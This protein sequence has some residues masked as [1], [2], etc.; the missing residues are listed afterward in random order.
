MSVRHLESW[1]S[2]D[3]G[4]IWFPVHI[5]LHP[6]GR[7]RKWVRAQIAATALVTLFRILH[8]SVTANFG[9][10]A[11][12]ERI[13]SHDA[14][15]FILYYHFECDVIIVLQLARSESRSA[16]YGVFPNKSEVIG[17]ERGSE[18]S[19]LPA[20]EWRQELGGELYCLRA[21]RPDHT[22][23]PG[24]FQVPLLE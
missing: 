6:P 14:S 8:L 11:E 10:E 4:E 16:R 7:V 15:G 21:I 5:G 22:F 9:Y 19:F 17:E 3:W 12:E 1:P 20:H 18:G 13:V 2:A 23:F 24:V